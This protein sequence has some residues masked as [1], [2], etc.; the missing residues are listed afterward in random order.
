MKGTAYGAQKSFTT[1]NS[2]NPN[3]GQP[4]PGTPTVTDHEGNVYNTVQIGNQCWTKENLRTT[5][6]P[7]TG[8]YLIPSSGTGYTYSGKQARWYNEVLGKR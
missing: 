4:C 1:A 6:S 2:G 8:T 5:T 7:S 3:D